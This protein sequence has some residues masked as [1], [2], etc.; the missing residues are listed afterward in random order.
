MRG[1][2]ADAQ[3][4]EIAKFGSDFAYRANKKFRPFMFNHAKKFYSLQDGIYNA[5]K[6][7]YN[8]CWDTWFKIEKYVAGGGTAVYGDY[9][10]CWRTE[11]PTRIDWS[12]YNGGRGEIT[13]STVSQS[14]V[15]NADGSVTVTWSWQKDPPVPDEG[16]FS[17]LPAPDGTGPPSGAEGVRGAYNCAKIREWV[18]RVDYQNRPIPPEGYKDTV[19]AK[20]SSSFEAR[21]R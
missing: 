7:Y 11:A 4:F 12:S 16:Y 15:E 10:E 8:N 3:V 19:A 20:I 5:Y 18:K 2:K 17:R 1:N 14:Q 13:Q 21:N 6:D 9:Q